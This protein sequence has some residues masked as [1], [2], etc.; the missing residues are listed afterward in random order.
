RKIAR[1]IIK[2]YDITD[3]DKEQLYERLKPLAEAAALSKDGTDAQWE[4]IREY[5]RAV[6]RDVGENALVPS[7]DAEYMRETYHEMRGFLKGTRVLNP[8]AIDPNNEK[9]TK[10][11]KE[12]RDYYR[13]KLFGTLTL[14][15][16][17]SDVTDLGVVYRELTERFGEGFFPSDK[18]NSEDMLIKISDVLDDLKSVARKT[19]GED[20]GSRYD[21]FY[22]A[23]AQDIIGRIADVREDPTFADKK[24]AEKAA[25]V[26]KERER[27]KERVNKLVAKERKRR[28]AAVSK[29]K[30]KYKAKTA[31]ARELKNLPPSRYLIIKDRKMFSQKSSLKLIIVFNSN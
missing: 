14:T 21:D 6:A 13:K 15:S 28:E 9:A 19:A 4:R 16:D 8:W 5:A 20:G 29:L 3:Y 18:T 10:R 31:E 22:E 1:G 24:A 2:D 7:E 26:A 23:I 12:L 25:A 17:P 30:D 27:A 11:N